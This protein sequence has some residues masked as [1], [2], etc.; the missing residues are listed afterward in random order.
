MVDVAQRRTE[1]AAAVWRVIR[2]DGL[3]HASVRNVARESGWSMGALRHYFASQDELVAFAM[4]LVADRA[5]DRAVAAHRAAPDA[6]SAAVALLEQVLPLDAERLEEAQVW[7]A[8]TARSFTDERMARLRHR[9]YDDLHRVCEVA[10][11]ALLPDAQTRAEDHVRLEV[12]RLYALVDGLALHAVTRPEA[13]P[14]H[15]V[16]D[17]LHAHLRRLEGTP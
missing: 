1:L 10:V 2:R 13:M 17:V 14:P 11:G 7:L 15:R 5:R 4:E 8:F 12:E 16:R 9:S 3:E 6:R